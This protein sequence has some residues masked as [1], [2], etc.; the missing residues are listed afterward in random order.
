MQN[1]DK[2]SISYQQLVKRHHPSTPRMR[3][4]LV[5]F[6]VGGG[7]SL[8]SQSVQNL[9]QNMG[10]ELESASSL[11]TVFLIFL[12]S[13]LTGLGL[14]DRIVSFAGAG[15]LVPVTGFANAMVAPAM[16]FKQDGYILGMGGK[17]F[18][19]AGPVFTYGIV[20]GF[21]VGL[22]TYLTQLL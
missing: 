2:D 10:M 1:V 20:T 18:Q 21:F 16:E 15:A 6:A 11:S 4:F 5:A 9:L 19:V 22:I 3:N 17:M 13:I 14:Y 8:L 12:G 7:F